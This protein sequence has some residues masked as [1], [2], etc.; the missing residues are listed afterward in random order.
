MSVYVLA[1]GFWLS[2]LT[3]GPAVFCFAPGY[4]PLAIVGF[5]LLQLFLVLL[6]WRLSSLDFG[7]WVDE[8][9]FAGILK[10]ARYMKKIG[11]GGKPVWWA[12]PFEL[13]WCLS[14]KYFA[15]F[16]LWFI[17]SRAISQD[18]LRTYGN[19]HPFWQA[20]GLAIPFMGML[21]FLY[22]VAFGKK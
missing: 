7:D 10:L 1:T 15:P 9:G 5:W 4:Y 8:V 21:M 18:L 6:S 14:I 17:I 12:G 16:A 20:I 11:S 22:F 2:L 19:Y 3:I 13:Y